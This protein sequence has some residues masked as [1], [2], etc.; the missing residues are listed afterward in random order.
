VQKNV[1]G[2]GSYFCETTQSK[3]WVFLSKLQETAKTIIHHISVLASP[4]QG[5][6]AKSM[7]V[8]NW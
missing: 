1:S 6:M 8:Q 2:T 5:V 3:N 4:D 7:R